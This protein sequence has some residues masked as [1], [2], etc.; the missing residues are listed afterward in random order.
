MKK[1][2]FKVWMT[3]DHYADAPVWL[4]LRSREPK[5]DITGYWQH[6]HGGLQNFCYQRFIRLTGITLKRR[7]KTLVEVTMKILDG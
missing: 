3:R 6:R 1:R 4:W 2:T 7:Q 5:L